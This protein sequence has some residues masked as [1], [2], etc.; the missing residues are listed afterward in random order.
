MR[1]AF[2]LFILL[3]ALGAGGCFLIG[4]TVSAQRDQVTITENVLWGETSAVEDLTVESRTHYD[5]YLF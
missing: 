3:L 4:Q 5:E 1:K 2:G